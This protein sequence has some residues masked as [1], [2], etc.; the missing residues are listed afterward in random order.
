MDYT[1][2]TSS[3]SYFFS[4]GNTVSTNQPA[5]SATSKKN[6]VY[7]DLLSY[8]SLIISLQPF[9]TFRPRFIPHVSAWGNKS[10]V[11]SRKLR[12]FSSKLDLTDPRILVIVPS[13][14][15]SDNLCP[16]QCVL[17][18]VTFTVTYVGHNGHKDGTRTGHINLHDGWISKYFI[19]LGEL[20][21]WAVRSSGRARN[22]IAASIFCRTCEAAA[23]RRQMS[24]ILMIYFNFRVAGVHD[25]NQNS[26]I[27][28]GTQRRYF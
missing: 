2:D 23:S 12:Y 24:M 18:I 19:Q 11:A 20:W 27:D 8:Q 10:G 7:E 13:S 16:C 26:M 25:I 3:W 1:Q 21:S 5:C 4:C 9:A 6:Q 15:E 14:S 22:W 28:N 17:Q